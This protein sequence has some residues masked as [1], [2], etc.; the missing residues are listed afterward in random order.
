[1]IEH[2]E[3]KIKDIEIPL[4]QLEQRV[5]SLESSF[6]SYQI[7][8]LDKITLEVANRFNKNM[9][10]HLPVVDKAIKDFK[11]FRESLEMKFQQVT[12][13]AK[14]VLMYKKDLSKLQ[15]NMF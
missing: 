13:D 1:M 5:E 3:A 9:F 12:E 2:N 15:E 11:S 10:E 14:E 8:V 6:A 7:N 4:F